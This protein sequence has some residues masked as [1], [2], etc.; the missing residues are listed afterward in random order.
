M[1][2]GTAI[3]DQIGRHPADKETIRIALILPKASKHV[4]VYAY[5]DCSRR[6]LFCLTVTRLAMRDGHSGKKQVSDGGERAYKT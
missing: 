1:E 3:I 5:I 4:I 2:G 6:Q